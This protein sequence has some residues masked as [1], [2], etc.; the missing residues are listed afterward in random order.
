MLGQ[1]KGEKVVIMS[2]KAYNVYNKQQID[3]IRSFAK[4]IYCDIDTQ[5]K[6]T[7]EVVL[8]ACLQKSFEVITPNDE[9]MYKF[10]L[11]RQQINADV[12]YVDQFL[13]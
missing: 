11:N 10:E 4:I 6:D 1:S 2:Q 9:Y 7:V 12:Y 13:C 5:L 8:A 3:K